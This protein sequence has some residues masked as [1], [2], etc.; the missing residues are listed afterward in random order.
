MAQPSR[1]KDQTVTN[2]K[3]PNKRERASA[4]YGQFNATDANWA[5]YW[6][7]SPPETILEAIER[8]AD[9]VSNSGVSP[10]A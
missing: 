8:L 2:A 7:G 4:Q 5:T 1:V 3:V 10:I 6:A 9:A